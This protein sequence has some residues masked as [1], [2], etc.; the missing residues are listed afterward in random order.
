LPISM[1]RPISAWGSI[2]NCG[3]AMGSASVRRRRSSVSGLAASARG[4]PAPCRQ[5]VALARALVRERPILLLDEPFAALDPGLRGDM[6]ALLLDL[7]RDA[8]NTILIVTHHPDD[9][10]SLADR[11][12]CLEAGRILLHEEAD[13]FLARVDPPSVARFLGKT[14]P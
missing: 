3:L 5:R 7:H 9:V 1:W 11:V 12:M 8:G 4:F 6:G 2:R 10:R 13:A 14:A